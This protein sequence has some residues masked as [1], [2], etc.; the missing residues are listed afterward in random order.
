[1]LKD[2]IIKGLFNIVPFF[3]RTIKIVSAILIV[4]TMLRTFFPHFIFLNK[5]EII[6]SNIKYSF[7][8]NEEFDEKELKKLLDSVN[9]KIS[10]ASI[11]K[12]FSEEKV[13]VK[14]LIC[15]SRVL[16]TFLIPFNRTGFAT[17]SKLTN[18]VY[19]SNL[20]MITGYSS[21]YPKSKEINNTHLLSHEITHLMLYN[22]NIKLKKWM[23][24]GYCE[25]I[26]Y[27]SRPNVQKL[28]QNEITKYM[29]Y[30]LAVEFLL[31]Q[32]NNDLKRLENI[33]KHI[34]N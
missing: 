22:A 8:S 16:Y 1:M 4:W 26:A 9:C 3:Y 7:Y 14:L 27:N 13:S 11:F 33:D 19:V 28:F 34:L 18:H 24:E 30:M 2:K 12:E 17:S 20:N 25:Y 29:Q 23:E 10:K 32:S 21:T 5:Y 6:Y 31:K 15:N